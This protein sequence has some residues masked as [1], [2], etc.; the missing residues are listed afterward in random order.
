MGDCSSANSIL[1]SPK[2]YSS[3]PRTR[4]TV[5]VSRN[6]WFQRCS[7]G[8]GMRCQRRQGEERC[9][10]K[11]GSSWRQPM[12]RRPALPDCT[13]RP[14]GRTAQP[15]AACTKPLNGPCGQGALL[16][17]QATKSFNGPYGQGPLLVA[18][19]TKP[20]NGPYGQG[21]LLV[22]QTT[23]TCRVNC[24]CI[25]VLKSTRPAHTWGE[26]GMRR[27]CRRLLLLLVFY[28]T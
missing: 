23:A 22:A 19:A 5:T 15:S 7:Q 16:V 2:S 4:Q 17:A 1:L 28:R 24:G 18:Q 3:S 27:R 8:S 11:D 21:P 25:I 6:T 12:R 10:R 14:T 20:L 9:C 13:A 26:A